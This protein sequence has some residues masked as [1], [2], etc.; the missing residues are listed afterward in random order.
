MV[1]VFVVAIVVADFFGLADVTSTVV[2]YVIVDSSDSS[3]CLT[4]GGVC[5]A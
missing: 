1:I 5:L 2:V 3:K 4:F